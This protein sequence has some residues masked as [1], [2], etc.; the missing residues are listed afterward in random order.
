MKKLLKLFVLLSL[1]GFVSGWAGEIKA[2]ILPLDQVKAGQKGKGRSVFEG[3]KVED[4]DVEILGVLR[5]FQPKKSIILA[6]LKS[7]VLEKTGVISGMSGSPVYVDGKLIGA[8]A[9]SFP[10]ATEAIAGI[11]PIGEMMAI[12]KESSPRSSYSAAFPIQK[13]LTLEELYEKTKAFF[14]VSTPSV[15]NGQTITPLDVPLIFSGFSGPVFEKA[16][17]FFSQM[18]F[19]PVRTGQAG[20]T[21]EKIAPPDLSIR[22][23]DAVGVQLVSGDLDISAVGTATL[24]D[25][26]K[27]LAFGHPLY[28]LGAVDY[29]MTKANVITVVPSLSNSF[30]LAATDIPVGRFVQDRTSGVLGELGKMPQLVPLNIKM[31]DAKSD[32]QE[33]HMKVVNDKILTPFLVNFV[34]SNVLSS[35][36]RAVGD[37][38]LMLDG[39]IYLDNGMSIHLEDLFSGNF[40]SSVSDLSSLLTAVV[41]FLTN[42]EFKDLGI[43]RIDLNI[44]ASEE[45]K[46]SYLENVWLDK[47][48][49]SPGERIQIKIYTRDFRGESVLQEVGI[50]APHLPLGSEFYLVIADAISLRQLETHQYRSQTFMP[51]SLSQLIRILNNLRKNNSIYFKIIA[52][53]PGLFLKGEEMPNL[54]PSMKSLFS[55]PRAAV[56]SPVELTSSTLTEYQLPVPFVFKGAVLIPIKIKK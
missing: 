21:L 28:N 13:H 15:V 12:F 38:S 53:K 25:G 30:K 32:V 27:V 39:D 14:R 40:D 2:E 6:R 7:P 48:D 5:N 20:K 26:N 29:V 10:Y 42:N 54:P 8:V 34:V 17:P 41:F 46:F 9:Y 50:V 45:V 49:V 43:H 33:F 24:V 52:A 31:Q 22:E 3:N 55:S 51:R 16:K 23:G 18:G 47:Y 37:L 1:L 56:S 19:N 11:T 4:F 35:E 44:Q 36:E